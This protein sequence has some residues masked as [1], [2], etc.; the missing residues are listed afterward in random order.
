MIKAMS[1]FTILLIMSGCATGGRVS[2][3]ANVQPVVFDASKSYVY[4][5]R[6]CLIWGAVRGIK[7]YDENKNIGGLNCSTYFIYETNPGGHNFH[8]DDWIRQERILTMV[9]E[10][11]KKY[12]VKTDLRIG[13]M[14]AVPS[15]TLINN[16]NEDKMNQFRRISGN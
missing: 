10:P 4:F 16:L 9:L 11:G 8:A 2:S 7:V 1:L 5:Y 3:N 14:D 12:F 6:P 15:L 13:L